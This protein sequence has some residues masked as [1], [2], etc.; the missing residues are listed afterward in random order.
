MQTVKFYYFCFSLI[1]VMFISVI[2]ISLS[3]VYLLTK[4]EADRLRAETELIKTEINHTKLKIKLKH[5]EDDQ[6]YIEN[7]IR[8]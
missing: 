2:G 4:S 8:H 7:L 3:K 5:L 6:K 1:A